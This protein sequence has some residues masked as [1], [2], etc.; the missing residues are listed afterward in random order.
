[1]YEGE[2]RPKT[3]APTIFN[4]ETEA[5]I[6]LFACHCRLLRIPQSRP[7]LRSDLAH[8]VQNSP[9]LNIRMAKDGPGE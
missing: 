6:A 7:I 2:V 4:E 3:G 5:D 8:F 1:M 9:Q